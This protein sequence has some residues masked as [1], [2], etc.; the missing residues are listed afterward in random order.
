MTAQ[1]AR[2]VKRA[3]NSK[4]AGPSPTASRTEASGVDVA[5]LRKTLGLTRKLFSRLTGYSERAIAKWEGDEA[6]GDASRQR[7][8]EIQRFQQALAGVMKSEFVGTWLQTPNDAFGGLKPIEVIERG[9]I[10]RLWRMIH[11]LESGTPG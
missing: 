2:T 10:D 6:L 9:E 5:A 1:L 8:R 7:M 3:S 11:E 4:H